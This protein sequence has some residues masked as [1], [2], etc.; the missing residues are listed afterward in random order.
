M[1]NKYIAYNYK[2]ITLHSTFESYYIFKKK[3]KKIIER[4]FSIE[5]NI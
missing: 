3:R 2:Y 4:S 5:T 1:K